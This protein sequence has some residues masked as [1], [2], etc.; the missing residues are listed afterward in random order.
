MLEM[1]RNY[2]IWDRALSTIRR[3]KTNRIKVLMEV[4]SRAAHLC[5]D[6]LPF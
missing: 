2:A 4:T 3:R 6:A 5:R 1:A